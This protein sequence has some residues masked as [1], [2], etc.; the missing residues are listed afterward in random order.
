MFTMLIAVSALYTNTPYSY[1]RCS[2]HSSFF[3]SYP[4]CRS[5][6]ALASSIR[7][8]KRDWL[9]TRTLTHYEEWSLN[10]RPNIFWKSDLRSKKQ[11]FSKFQPGIPVCERHRTTQQQ[12][13][14][15]QVHM[16]GVMLTHCSEACGAGRVPRCSVLVLTYRLQR[17]RSFFS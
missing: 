15:R 8:N 14:R 7:E 5:K 10:S 17:R 16:T 11:K 2:I 12:L 6:F 9:E 3:V 13:L 4:T 1:C